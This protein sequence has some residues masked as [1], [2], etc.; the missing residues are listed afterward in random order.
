MKFAHL[1]NEHRAY[2][3]KE[4]VCRVQHVRPAKKM[5]KIN[6]HVITIGQRNCG[7]N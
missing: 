7:V 6:R 5:I 1:F 3:V 2:G 4:R